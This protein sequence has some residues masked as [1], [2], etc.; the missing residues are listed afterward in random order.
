MKDR[1]VEITYRG[2]VKTVLDDYNFLMKYIEE[3]PFS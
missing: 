2:P 1:I 3:H